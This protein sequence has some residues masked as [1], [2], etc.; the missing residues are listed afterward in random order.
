[1][2]GSLQISQGKECQ[3]SRDL[4]QEC[5]RFLMYARSGIERAPLQVY[6][7]AALF[8]PS[9]SVLR[10][11]GRKTT[12]LSYVK[13]S[14]ARPEHW[15]ALLLTLEGH[16]HVVNAVQ[17][18]PDGSKLASASDDNNVVVWDPST[19][20]P[21]HT[22]EGH[23]D[24]VNAVQFS[25]DGSKLASASDDKNVKVWDASTGAQ[26][27]TLEGHSTGVSAVQFSPNSSKLAS[28][29]WDSN[30][31]VWD[32]STGA[33]LHT[34]EGHSDEVNAVQFSPDGSKLASASWDNNVIVW[35]LNTTSPIQ[36]IDVKEYVTNLAFSSDGL[37]LNT[38]IGSFKLEFG[39]GESHDENACTF[40]HQVADDWI[41]RHGQRTI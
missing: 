20:T 21:L 32:A 15:G 11:I 14:P 3:I 31:I 25:P 8:A 2:A 1:M 29:S 18:S 6:V 36:T 17:F 13:R 4:V 38:N 10:K 37:S 12:F 19:G 23:S 34:L 33:Q 35:D 27:H 26:L 7:S 5:K 39:V 41:L 9:S 22:L 24:A 40:R 16:S 28:G 30:V